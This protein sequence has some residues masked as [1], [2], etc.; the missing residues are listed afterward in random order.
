[1]EKVAVLRLNQKKNSVPVSKRRL[2]QQMWHALRRYGGLN[3]VFSSDAEM[4][5]KATELRQMPVEELRKKF[6]ISRLKDFPPWHRDG[7]FWTQKVAIRI[8]QW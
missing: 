8:W 4:E 3:D 2:Q 7:I 5:A 1:M 6:E